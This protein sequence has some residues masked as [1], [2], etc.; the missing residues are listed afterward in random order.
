VIL[1]NIPQISYVRASSVQWQGHDLYYDLQLYELGEG[2]EEF[3]VFNPNVERSSLKDIIHYIDE[4][5][6]SKKCVVF[7]YEGEWVVKLF[8]DGWYPYHGY[9]T[10]E[11]VKPK[12]IWTRNPDVDKLITFENNPFG[13]FD[14]GP[15]DKDY[16]LIWYIDPRFN[17]LPDKVWAFSCHPMGKEV[18]GTKDMGYVV[19]DVSVEYSKYLPDLGIQLDECFPPFYDLDYECAYELDKK[20]QTDKQLWVVKFSPNW[21]KPKGWR[22]L[23]TVEPQFEV[24]YNPALPK[25]HYDLDYIIP[26]HD[27]GYEHIWM[28]DRRFLNDGEEDIWAFKIRATNKIE[29]T[30]NMGYIDP[31]FE[32]EVNPDLPKIKGD[33]D[34]IVPWH[35]LGYEHVWYVDHAGEK[36][37][38]A[39]MR[40]V[41]KPIGIKEVGS[42]VPVLERLDVIFISYNEPN[43]DANWN[44]VLEKAPYA[45][46]VHGVKGIFEA[47]KAAAKLAKTDMFYVV[48]GDAYLVDDW[49]FDFQPSLFDRDCAYVWSSQNPVNGLTY[50]YGGVKLFNK[51]ILMKKRSWTTLDMFSTMPKIKAEDAISCISTFNT[52]KFSTWR[53][54]FREVVK[55]YVANQV[56]RIDAWLSSDVAEPFGD[57]AQAGAQ[58]GYDYARTHS[59]NSSAL[60]KINDYDWL[61]KEFK[62]INGRR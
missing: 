59:D 23:G 7:T 42:V 53:S 45:K 34:Y 5:P 15:W 33:L 13:D 16:K 50:Q 58:A 26:W 14:P 11:I 8:K 35:D 27:L 22:W 10:V 36:V 46:R 56:T 51:R 60:I 44:R 25:L 38:A 6:Y 3:W 12:L 18:I 61:L 31:N 17:P 30:R 41:D 2:L 4:I 49:Q 52:D 32:I 47:H 9:E 1:D 43:A 62:K 28:L 55:L 40:A 21:R 57:Y 48:D 19:P 20:Y 29:G 37:W 54:A 24:K 39:K